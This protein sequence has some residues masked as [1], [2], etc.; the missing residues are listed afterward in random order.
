[1][2]LED[3]RR[4]HRVRA[5]EID[6]R[7]KEE[8]VLNME[9]R[10]TQCIAELLQRRREEENVRELQ[11]HV[12][13]RR[14]ELEMKDEIQHQEW[15]I[16][17][18]RERVDLQAMRDRCMQQDRQ[19]AK[20]RRQR[21]IDMELRLQELD[22]QLRMAQVARERM[23]RRAHFDAAQTAQASS[24]LQR[25]R[26][27]L[28][29]RNEIRDT[30]R[31]EEVH[32]LE[33]EGWGRQ[34]EE[35]LKRA[36]QCVQEEIAILG[37]GLAG[38]HGSATVDGIGE[39]QRYMTTGTESG[40]RAGGEASVVASDLR[41]QELEDLIRHREAE[42]DKLW[43]DFDAE[44]EQLADEERR[45]P[46]FESADEADAEQAC[47]GCGGAG[48]DA[49]GVPYVCPREEAHSRVFDGCGSAA[50]GIAAGAPLTGSWNS[51]GE[52]SY[53]LGRWGSSHALPALRSH[54][55]RLAGF[56]R[57]TTKA[58]TSEVTPS[59]GADSDSG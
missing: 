25:K 57:S 8:A 9:F 55:S 6:A 51:S 15:R 46:A 45:L 41:E 49:G 47:G 12:R 21:E 22:R 23:L 44:A 11:C 17:D 24:E 1:M 42:L 37:A 26:H 2:L 5:Y 40:L 35:R 50:A 16:A 13:T 19:E 52:D 36:L 29:A 54:T 59:W 33:A 43:R 27:E 58:G 4:R 48:L 18:E 28:A 20:F 31:R 53:G 34:E 14:R 7:L 3:L 38:A 30:S 32:E 10:G 56:G 39:F